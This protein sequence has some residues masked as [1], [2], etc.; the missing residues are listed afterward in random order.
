MFILL[1]RHFLNAFL[2]DLFQNK[3]CVKAKCR[4]EHVKN[5]LITYIENI[6]PFY[7]YTVFTA[8]ICF[9]DGPIRSH[10]VTFS[11]KSAF[12]GGTHV[13]VI[14]KE[15]AKEYSPYN[16]ETVFYSFERK[17]YIGID[18]VCGEY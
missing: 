16:V 7:D 17:G 1:F 2:H 8:A 9:L 4:E 11:I 6:N 10:Q 5:S 3:F 18:N 13:T 14:Y 12:G 15:D